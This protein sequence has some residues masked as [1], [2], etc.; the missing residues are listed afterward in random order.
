MDMRELVITLVIVGILFI[1]GV[2]IFSAVKNAGDNIIDP[3]IL[4]QIYDT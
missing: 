3:D 4:T 1:V 2:L